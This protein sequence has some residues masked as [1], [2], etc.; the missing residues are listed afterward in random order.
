ME[1]NDVLHRVRRL[2]GLALVN[3]GATLLLLAKAFGL[4]GALPFVGVLF[5]R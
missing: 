2:E 1:R 5:G 3:L 4:A